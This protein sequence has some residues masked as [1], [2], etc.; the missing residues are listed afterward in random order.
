MLC[1]ELA[2]MLVWSQLSASEAEQLREQ[3]WRAAFRQCRNKPNGGGGGGV[4]LR[5]DDCKI[6][7]RLDLKINLGAEGVQVSIRLA[8][9]NH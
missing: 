3:D 6:Q 7:V 4:T 5:R 8:W 9:E 1:T 2:T